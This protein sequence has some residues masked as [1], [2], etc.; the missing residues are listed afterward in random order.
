MIRFINRDNELNLLT[1][2]WNKEQAQFIVIYGR[3]RIGKTS[4]ITEFTKNKKGVFYI[5]ED[6]NKK[7]QIHDFK[8]KIANYFQ[9]DLL[10]N[11]EIMKWKDLFSYLEKIIPKNEKMHITI[12]EFSYFIKNDPSLTSSLQKFWDMFLSKTNIMLI[13][14]GSI[15]GLMSEKILSSSSPLYGRRSRDLLLKEMNFKNSS[16][17]LDMAF[18]EKLKTYMTIGGVPEYLLKAKYYPDSKEFIEKEFINHDGYFFREPYFLLSQE[19]KEIKT[20]FT[21]INA[22]AYGNTKPSHISN[23]AGIRTR[24]IYPYLENLIRLN[25]IKKITPIHNNRYGIYI[26]KDVFFDFWFNFVHKNRDKIERN[27][28]KLSKKDLNTYLGK[29]FEIIVRDEFIAKMIKA[30][31][32]EKWWYKD[33][34]IDI[35]TVDNKNKQ[36][37]FLECKYKSL[38]YNLVLNI[39]KDLENKSSHVNLYNDERKEKFGVIAKKIDKKDELRKQ[40]FLVYDFQDWK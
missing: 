3:R 30:D 17:F 33:K 40:G 36:I 16:F 38:S 37:N 31:T 7:V 12:D 24:E 29:R 1:E 32:I 21:I 26:I 39:I 22:I 35:V 23:F 27:Q 2:E 25:F 19:F 34:E 13:V 15:F 4:L 9:D 18:E 28:Y 11:L 8:E 6:V 10:K 14:S 20:Y 5:A